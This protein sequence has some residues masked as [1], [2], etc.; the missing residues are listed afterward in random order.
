M[1]ILYV[2]TSTDVGGAENAL[3]QL[4][5]ASSGKHQIRVV[6]L[7]ELGPQSSALKHLGAQVVSLHMK[8]AGLGTVTKLVRELEIFQP[9]LVHAILFRAIEF[10]RLAC[11]GRNIK[12]ITTPH[13]DLSQKPLWMRWLDRALKTIDTVST[14]ESASTYNYLTL[15][16]HYPPSKTLFIGNSVEKS[17]F[18]KDNSLR[19]QMRQQKGFKP[20]DIVFVSVARLAYVKNPQG[21]IKAF[22]QIVPHCPHAKL[23]LVGDG[24]ERPALEKQ[25]N[26]LKLTEKICLA[27]EQQDVNGW[28]NMAD[29]FVLLSREESLPLA[30]LEAQ[31]VGLPC[32]VSPVGDMPKYVEHGQTG[33]VCKPD[34]PTLVACFLTELYTNAEL[35]RE[36]GEKAYQKASQQVDA[37]QQYQQLYQRLVTKS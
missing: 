28:L 36:M 29:V 35:R 19:N 1:K 24:V 27:G 25:I 12:L 16:Q 26:E 15:H 31:Q 32:V 21:L 7:K 3:V 23:V 33:Y 30:L 6:C 10:T 18:F 2:I 17:L 5:R 34:Q 4:V 20:E 13:F 9:D 14:A 22:A 37:C 11:A 8:G